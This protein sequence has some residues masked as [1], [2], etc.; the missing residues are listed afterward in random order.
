MEKVLNILSL[1]LVI[2][3]KYYCNCFGFDSN[4]HM[5]MNSVLELGLMLNKEFK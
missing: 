3:T 1:D 5:K 2:A 4:V